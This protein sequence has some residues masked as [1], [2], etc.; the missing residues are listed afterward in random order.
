M[1]YINNAK[2]IKVLKI[3]KCKIVENNEIIIDTDSNSFT[4]GLNNKILENKKK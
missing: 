3:L 4:D 1:R 2:I